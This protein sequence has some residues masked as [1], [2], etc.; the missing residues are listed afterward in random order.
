MPPCLDVYVFSDARDRETL[1]RFVE[2]YVDRSASEDRGDEE[3]MILRVG[4]EPED[5]DAWEWEPARTLTHVLERALD[6]P[7]RAFTVYLDTSD[8]RCDRA[9]LAFTAD[10]RVVFGLSVDDPLGEDARL[11]VAQSILLELAGSV[12]ADEGLITCEEPP[13]I[14]KLDRAR[15]SRALFTWPS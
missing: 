8:A 1:G 10:D 6:R 9:I 2:L 5:P 7:P 3:L 15:V 13:P 12:F 11:Q 4:S 14:T